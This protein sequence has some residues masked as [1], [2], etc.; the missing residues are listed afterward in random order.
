MT[1]RL[2]TTVAPAAFVRPLVTDWKIDRRV[3][4]RRGN[5]ARI[6]LRSMEMGGRS[7]SHEHDPR[8]FDC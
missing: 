7:D 1:F 2:S 4:R 8:A 6:V 5:V 3:T